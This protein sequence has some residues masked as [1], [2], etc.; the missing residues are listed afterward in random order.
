MRPEEDMTVKANM[1]ITIHPMAINANGS[2]Y[3]F[4]CDNFIVTDS[5]TIRIHK[6]PREIFVV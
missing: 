2:A 5:G 6:T 1:N 4:C 3:V